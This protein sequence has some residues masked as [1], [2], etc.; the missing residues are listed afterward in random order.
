MKKV[1][2]SFGAASAEFK[3]ELEGMIEGLVQLMIDNMEILLKTRTV[4]IFIALLEN[5]SYAGWVSSPHPD[6]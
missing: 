6:L 4:F 1:I 2:Q 5:T 3:T